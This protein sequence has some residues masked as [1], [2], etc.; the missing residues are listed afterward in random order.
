[1]IRDATTLQ[2]KQP[3]LKANGRI[4]RLAFSPD[5]KYL[6]AATE[7]NIG[8]PSNDGAVHRQFAAKLWEAASGT[9]VRDFLDHK[10]EVTG[11]AFSPNG[12]SL[13]TSSADGRLRIW[14][15]RDLHGVHPWK[16]LSREHDANFGGDENVWMAE[17]A[18]SAVTFA[19]NGRLASAMSV[20]NFAGIW[21][22]NKGK[23]QYRLLGHEGGIRSLAYSGAG[24]KHKLATLGADHKIRLYYL[25]TP[26]LVARAKLLLK[27][28]QAGPLGSR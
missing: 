20:Q 24:G 28:S 15:L 2:I 6:A 3:P 16:E 17:Y 1:L 21:D 19:E 4:N 9:W 5:G 13:A 14:D 7:E 10:R 26:D 8:T 22:V 11:V 27:T 23:L 25:E 18:F 12:E